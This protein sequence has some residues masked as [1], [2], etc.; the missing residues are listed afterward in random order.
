ME[1]PIP[2]VRDSW[3]DKTELRRNDD[4]GAINEDQ[5]NIK[6]HLSKIGFNQNNIHRL[7]Y[8]NRSH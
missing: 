8:R 7:N 6:C 2:N 5:A 4:L 3:A 1:L